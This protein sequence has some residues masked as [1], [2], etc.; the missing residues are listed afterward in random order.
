VGH[1]LFSLGIKAA[2]PRS[3]GAYLMRK[4]VDRILPCFMNAFI[5]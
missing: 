3:V 2:E 4:L 1:L 5:S